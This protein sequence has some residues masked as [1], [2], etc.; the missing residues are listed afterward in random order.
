M[1]QGSGE[2]FGESSMPVPA[3]IG[4]ERN[5]PLDEELPGFVIVG[6][7]IASSD[8][9]ESRLDQVEIYPS[10]VMVDV[11]Y[12]F[13]NRSFWLRHIGNPRELHPPAT[14]GPRLAIRSSDGTRPQDEEQLRVEP[15]DVRGSGPDWNFRY[16]IRP[17][18]VS[19]ITLLAAWEDCGLPDTGW[20]LT[21]N[22]ID[23][24]LRRSAELT[25]LRDTAEADGF[26]ISTDLSRIA[27]IAARL[28]DLGGGLSVPMS[29]DGHEPVVTVPLRQGTVAI[30]Q[31]TGE[32][33]AALGSLIQ[34]QP[35]H[36][37]TAEGA[38]NAQAFVVGEDAAA[39]AR[40]L[41]VAIGSSG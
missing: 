36:L 28:A 2:S 39:I 24:G 23:Q 18:P 7:R 8:E 4:A 40:A 19:D 5:G 21:R 30:H 1:A 38:V 31:L 3:D 6:E 29:A 9:C 32:G 15:A 12:R 26:P 34:G 20:Q 37:V 11:G 41:A 25:S 22:L 16:W 13:S 27:G 35:V 14:R 17:L 10:G 33:V